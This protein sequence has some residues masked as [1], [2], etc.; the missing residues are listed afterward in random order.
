MLTKRAPAVYGKRKDV[1][2]LLNKKW[3]MMIAVFAAV[4]IVAAVVL[5]TLPKA[6]STVPASEPSSEPV[7]SAVDAFTQTPGNAVT[8]TSTV[9][10]LIGTSPLVSV[11]GML[12]RVSTRVQGD[13]PV[14]NM[15]IGDMIEVVYD[16]RIAESYPG[17][18]NYVYAIR[19]V[20]GEHP[21]LTYEFKP[22]PSAHKAKTLLVNDIYY[23]GLDG[24]DVTVDSI[25]MDLQQALQVGLVS[26]EYLLRQAQRDV[27]AGKATLAEYRD[28]GSKLYR[29]ADY[30][31]LK[32]NTIS[33][34]KTLYIGTPDLT[35]NVI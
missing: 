34:D 31:I 29:Y 3:L 11:N 10:N 26:P 30:A 20:D 7:S 33:G 18:I 2:K 15:A 25:S 22:K 12:C 13:E 23:Y 27:S 4:V 19:S 9:Y 28:G 21:P 5:L 16:G 1:M 6:P 17:Q 32:M 24:M 35:P 8:F 14:P